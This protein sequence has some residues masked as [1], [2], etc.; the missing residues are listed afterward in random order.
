MT[1]SAEDYY[2]DVSAFKKRWCNEN[3]IISNILTT[4]L[5]QYINETILDVGAGLGDIAKTVFPD[6]KAICI[7]LVLPPDTQTKQSHH[8]WIQGDFLN[9]TPQER[10]KTLLIVHSQQFLDDDVEAF[11]FRLDQIKANHIILVRNRNDDL[12]G[13]L[14]RWTLKYF[15]ESNP[16]MQ[17]EGFARGYKI[18]DSV[19]FTAQL[20]CD[21]FDTLCEQVGYLMVN[22]ERTFLEGI[23]AFL[24]D[25]L[26]KP[27]LSINEIIEVYG[28]I[29]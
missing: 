21:S 28:R 9:Y 4:N 12:I 16:E 29:N 17:I 24:Q 3:Q 15:P 26:T 6:K 22:N 7:D 20:Q 25:R 14:A 13:E 10:I 19:Q 1:Y 5:P 11:F 23:C 8:E 2:S 18:V 27:Q